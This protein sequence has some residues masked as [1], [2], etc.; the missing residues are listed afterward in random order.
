MLKNAKGEKKMKNERKNVCYEQKINKSI[1][2]NFDEKNHIKSTW[3]MVKVCFFLFL[4]ILVQQEV[5]ANIL[6]ITI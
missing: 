6:D 4:Y 3:Y 5:V 1:K 2:S